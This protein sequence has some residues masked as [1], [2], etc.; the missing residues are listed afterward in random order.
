MGVAGWR[1]GTTDVCP[2]RQKPWR[3][4]WVQI[5]RCWPTIFFTDTKSLTCIRRRVNDISVT[6]FC[7]PTCGADQWDRFLG[8][9]CCQQIGRCEQR[10]TVALKIFLITFIQSIRWFISDNKGPYLLYRQRDRRKWKSWLKRRPGEVVLG[11][12][13][14]G[15]WSLGCPVGLLVWGGW[16]PP[17]GLPAGLLIYAGCVEHFHGRRKYNLSV[18]LNGC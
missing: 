13:S 7:C 8:Q 18:E 9:I 11:F 1:G 4:Q 3:R 14:L 5:G 15:V 2:G 12:P 10:L 16:T 6:I 17:W